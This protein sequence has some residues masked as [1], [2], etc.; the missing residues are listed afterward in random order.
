LIFEGAILDIFQT[1]SVPQIINTSYVNSSFHKF[2][3]IKYFYQ[4]LQ[5]VC[6]R[7]DERSFNAYF[8]NVGQLHISPNSPWALILKRWREIS[9]QFNIEIIPPVPVRIIS[10]RPVRVHFVREDMQE[11]EEIRGKLI[12]DWYPPFVFVIR[13]HLDINEPIKYTEIIDLMKEQ[14]IAKVFYKSKEFN[15]LKSLAV[16]IK[17]DILF[18]LFKREFVDNVKVRLSEQY[19]FLFLR[20][21]TPLKRGNTKYLV[22]VAIQRK[23]VDKIP[24]E[25]IKKI[26]ENHLYFHIEEKILPTSR[27][28][29]VYSPE[30]IKASKCVRK[31]FR[32]KIT[33]GAI[34]AFV[35]KE[36][37]E[38]LNI[39]TENIITSKIS[40]FYYL[41][42]NIAS[43]YNPYFLAGRM[44]SLHLLDPTPLRKV[45]EKI[46]LLNKL[47]ETYEVTLKSFINQAS[48]ISLPEHILAV[49]N[50][51]N[52]H[53]PIFVE[54]YKPLYESLIKNINME[55]SIELISKLFGYKAS[56]LVEY[57][58]SKLE[59]DLKQEKARGE[60]LGCRRI[61]TILE[62]C[63]I[64]NNNK[65]LSKK[66]L[67]GSN[68]KPGI[69]KILKLVGIVKIKKEKIF[70]RPG[71][72]TF[73]CLNYNHPLAQL[74]IKSY[75]KQKNKE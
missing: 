25:D 75:N 66:D 27:G 56:K 35:L 42:T 72:A 53:P 52:L 39:L 67:Y 2:V 65:K 70:E 59:E 62:E 47:F 17:A 38:K 14:N 18:S 60:M 61:S 50:A 7:N 45:F 40:N 64:N 30:L 6:E 22:A 13:F 3:D 46:A 69:L 57:L 31:N 33:Y 16:A 28:V 71:R 11:I 37:L 68:G 10:Q 36:I 8:K 73:V 21:G 15:G 12:V 51:N 49:K 19:F 43:S 34:I 29:C 20:G 48:V 54:L 63:S 26:F 41:V 4:V 1:F 9:T 44:S 58:I 55:I 24:R 5:T 32:R 23:N 74:I